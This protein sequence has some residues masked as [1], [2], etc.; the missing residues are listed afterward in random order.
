MSPTQKKKK[1]PDFE[2]L[3]ENPP[4]GFEFAKKFLLSC[5][6]SPSVIS[7]TQAL[8]GCAEDGRC[9]M[10]EMM[11]DGR[12]FEMLSHLKTF[13]KKV[14]FP[15]VASEQGHFRDSWQDFAAE[16]LNENYLMAAFQ[17][18][19]P[20]NENFEDGKGRDIFTSNIFFA[21]S[22]DTTVHKKKKKRRDDYL[23]KIHI[24]P[25]TLPEF[26]TNPAKKSKVAEYKMWVKALISAIAEDQKSTIIDQDV[27][28]I[29]ELELKLG[30]INDR[31]SFKSNEE[32]ETI[33][34]EQ[35]QMAIVPSVRWLKYLEECF[36]T[37]PEFV[38]TNQ[39][40]VA[41]PQDSSGNFTLLKEMAAFVEQLERR[42]QANLLIWR[43]IDGFARNFVLTD[44]GDGVLQEKGFNPKVSDERQTCLA[45]LNTFFPWLKDDMLIA[46]YI[47][48]ETKDNVKEIFDALKFEFG[49]QIVASDWLGKTTKLAAVEKLNSTR[50][51]LGELQPASAEF[52]RMRERMAV[53]G[54]IGNLQEIGG[55]KWSTLVKSLGQ[56]K[57]IA[58]GN[59][60]ARNAFYYLNQNTV[61]MK[62][63]MIVNGLLGLGFSPSFPT[64][65]LYGGF[66]VLAHEIAHGFDTR[67]ARYNKDG[68]LG[69]EW[70]K[71]GEKEEF[72]KKADCLV[73]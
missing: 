56:Q 35:L 36:R 21:P 14:K 69:E 10:E 18:V 19:Q 29:V 60:E 3:V 59:E 2:E 7:P 57:H 70:W 45:Q 1:L 6:R 68:L 47:S 32:W 41:V 8:L 34:L 23:P 17:F 26:L 61:R 39:T 64:A 67:G 12:I 13:T 20:A 58:R 38:I 11:P 65:F 66:F 22:I 72:Y 31:H 40:V 46:K 55:F 30:E 4:D 37:N 28:R 24:V 42:E 71:K 15:A 33:S 27:E 54:F 73:T 52:D 25:M 5:E 53:K 49:L 63:G 16:Q 43:M 9:T 62:T 44:I 51:I 48:Q 50:L